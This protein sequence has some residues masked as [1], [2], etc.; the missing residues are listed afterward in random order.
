MASEDY[1]QIF[2]GLEENLGLLSDQKKL[3][4]QA[5]Y[6]LSNSLVGLGK[7]IRDEF[8][9]LH[10]TLRRIEQSK[11]PPASRPSNPSESD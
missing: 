8:A 3:E 11:L 6:N 9:E 10:R 7:V 4:H 2:E 1:D 5:L